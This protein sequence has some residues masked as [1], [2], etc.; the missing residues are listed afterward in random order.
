M[1][2]SLNINRDPGLEIHGEVILE[3]GDFGNQ[4]ADQRPVKLGDGAG[5]LFYEILQFPDL[6]HLLVLDDAVYLGLSALIP[7]AENLIRYG[8]VVVFLVDLLQEV[9]LQL[10]QALVYDLRREGIALKNHCGDVCP[11]RLQEI[12]LPAEYC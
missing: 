4:A 10:A 3:N 1:G 6:L 2:L 5:L 12:I 9:F 8:V 7:E 11:Q